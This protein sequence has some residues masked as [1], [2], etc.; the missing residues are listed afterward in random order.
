MPR[1][2]AGSRAGLGVGLGRVGG[3]LRGGWGRSLVGPALPWLGEG[4]VTA[5]NYST[6]EAPGRGEFPLTFGTV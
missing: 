1:L 4:W 6:W 2:Q 5:G 3:R